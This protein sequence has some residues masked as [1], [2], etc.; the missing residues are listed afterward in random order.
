MMNQK[1]LLVLLCGLQTMLIVLVAVIYINHFIS[2]PVMIAFLCSIS[3][4][5]L[6]LLLVIRKKMGGF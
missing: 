6:A 4:I 1:K 5:T 2:L 3:L